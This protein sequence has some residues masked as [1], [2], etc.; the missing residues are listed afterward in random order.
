MLIQGPGVQGH[1]GPGWGRPGGLGA[2]AVQ[3]V[4]GC[5]EHGPLRCG[6]AD[7]A[8]Q[9]PY[10]VGGEAVRQGA[11]D[12]AADAAEEDQVRGPGECPEGWVPG[13]PGHGRLRARTAWLDG[14]GG[15]GLPW[16]LLPS[17]QGNQLRKMLLQNYLQNRKS[18]SRGDLPDPMGT[19]QS[20]V[21]PARPLGSQFTP[22]LS[23]P[24]LH[25]PP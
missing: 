7:P 15:D 19:G 17:L 25:A 5:P 13:G 22:G 11:K 2:V 4:R 14:R 10:G 16:A 9:G 21:P 12:A 6:Q 1:N 23:F 3:V 18:S 8:H 24:S 20:C